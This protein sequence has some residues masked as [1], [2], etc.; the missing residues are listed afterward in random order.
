MEAGEEELLDLGLSSFLMLQLLIEGMPLQLKVTSI[1]C[2][3]PLDDLKILKWPAYEPLIY[4]MMSDLCS[5][6]IFASEFSVYFSCWH[7]H[8]SPFET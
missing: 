5:L 2:P 3:F 1:L 6:K 7:L 8:F 4:L